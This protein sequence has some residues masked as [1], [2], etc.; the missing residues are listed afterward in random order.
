[1]NSPTPLN[2]YSFVLRMLH[3]ASALIIVSLLILGFYM[4][5]IA[6]D[7]SNKYDLYPLHQ[8]FGMIL[9]LLILF[10]LPVRIKGVHPKPA[11][12]LK[13]WEHTL[14]QLVHILL[15]LAMISMTLSGYLMN[16]TYEYSQGIKMF[17]LFTVPDI[18]PKSEYWSNIF[19][20]IHSF[21]AWSFILLLIAHLAGVFKHR[22][23]DGKE[24]DVLQRML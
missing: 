15:Y 2:K 11:P 4:A 10:R 12:H 18:T 21:F 8:A 22:I 24:H 20:S 7:A 23:L 6:P 16:S 3:W 13:Q 9:L 19:H 17:G 14:A 1:M 5:D